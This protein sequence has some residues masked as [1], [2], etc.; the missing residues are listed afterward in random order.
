MNIV[1]NPRAKSIGVVRWMR[2]RQSVAIQEKT[3]IP[4]G[5]AMSSV[6]IIIGTRSQSAMPAT[7]MWCA[8]TE[9][10]RTRIPTKESAISR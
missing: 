6:V 3:L 7:N 9:K 10:P 8:H 4:V 1:T 2:P 5:M